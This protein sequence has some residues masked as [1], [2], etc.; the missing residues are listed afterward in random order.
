MRRQISA[1]AAGALSVI[2]GCTSRVPSPPAPPIP[3]TTALPDPSITTHLRFSP[4]I[5]RYRLTQT[6]Q[7][8]ADGLPDT[9]PSTS[10][11]G[12][13]FLVQV[14]SSDASTFEL[15]VSVDSINIATQGSIPPRSATPVRTLDSILHITITPSQTITQVYL[16]DSLCVYGHLISIAREILVPELPL[17]TESPSKNPYLDTATFTSCRAGVIVETLTTRQLRDSGRDPP[18][19]H[20]QQTAEFR[21]TGFLRRDSITVSGSTSTEGTLSFQQG[22]R[23]PSVL[24]SKS[25]GRI[26]VR[27]GI[28]TTVFQQTSSQKIHLETA[29]PP[30]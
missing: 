26:T 6:A 16:P 25:H 9:L 1:V 18:E 15:T 8:Q 10:I 29:N 19:F 4:G 21:G 13:L 22:N 11:T 14:T 7:I 20:I 23:L 17:L 3:S 2:G 5:Y 27:L 24:E 30:D 28:S 12:A